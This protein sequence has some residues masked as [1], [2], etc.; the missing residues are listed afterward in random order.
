M[1]ALCPAEAVAGPDVASIEVTATAWCF[2]LD[3][4]DREDVAEDEV[5]KLNAIFSKASARAEIPADH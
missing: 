4:I 3:A 1:I 5:A 2:K